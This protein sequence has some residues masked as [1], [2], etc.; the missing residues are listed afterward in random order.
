MGARKYWNCMSLGI[1]VSR[2]RV[3]F[4]ALRTYDC[5]LKVTHAVK[6][7]ASFILWLRKGGVP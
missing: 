7:A 1:H 4:A 5:Q 3:Q 6:V 2:V